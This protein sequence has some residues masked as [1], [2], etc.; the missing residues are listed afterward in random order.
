VLALG[1]FNANN[2]GG[3]YAPGVKRDPNDVKEGGV[4][5]FGH[6]VP[7]YL[8][9]NPLLEQLQIGATI[10]RVA[11]SHL[12]KTGAPQGIGAGAWAGLLGLVNE[13]PFVGGVSRMAGNTAPQNI[14]GEPIKSMIPG[15][16]QFTAEEMD[17]DNQ[18]NTI[19]RQPASVWQTVETGIPGLRQNVPARVTPDIAPIVNKLSRYLPKGT[20]PDV[21]AAQRA[22]FAE[23]LKTNSVPTK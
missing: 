16:L 10:R 20:P 18:G 8:V 6:D 23:F 13:V 3:Y 4:R 15:A 17:K 9:H 14:I 2:I 5:L 21:R 12:H 19:S 7:R 1:F 11:D 22:S